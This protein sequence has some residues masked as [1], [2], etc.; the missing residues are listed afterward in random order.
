MIP[1]QVFC[2]VVRFTGESGRGGTGFLTDGPGDGLYLV[3]VAHNTSGDREECVEIQQAWGALAPQGALLERIGDVSSGLDL[4][5]YS[6]PPNLRP[7]WYVGSVAVEASSLIYG[8]DC[9]ILGYPFLQAGE[10]FGSG[11]QLPLIKKACISGRMV[12]EDVTSWIVDTHANPGFSGAPLVYRVSGT[13]EY[14]IAG[15]VTQA[16]LGPTVEGG[17]MTTPAGFTYCLASEHIKV[18]I[19]GA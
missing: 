13:Q 12:R 18:L 15:V 8:Q 14:R 11:S 7:T 2:R 17:D 10:A 19:E 5:V 1:A 3:T 16:M 9:F 6:V 4:A